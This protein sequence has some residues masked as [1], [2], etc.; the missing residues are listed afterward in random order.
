[1]ALKRR[2]KL[3]AS[4][5][6]SSMTDMMF[7]LL[8]FFMIAST[9]SAPNDLKIKLPQS[10]SKAST[11]IVLAKVSINTD[12]QYYFAEGNGKAY[13]VEKDQLEELILNAMATDTTQ[14]VSLHA[15]QNIAYREVVDVLDIANRHHLKMVIATR[16][17]E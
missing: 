17:S 9:M 15:D 16:T 13:P 4:F 12:G 5:T 11:K 1:M 14:F 7:L 6:M 8:L 2:N 10:Q 3:S